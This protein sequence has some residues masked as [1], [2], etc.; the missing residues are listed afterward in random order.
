MSTRKLNEAA[1]A[2]ID[3]AAAADDT[4]LFRSSSCR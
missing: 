2:S 4:K 3:E 1:N